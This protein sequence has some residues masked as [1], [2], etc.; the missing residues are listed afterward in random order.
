VEKLEE[1]GIKTVEKLSEMKVDELTK[2]VDG[3]GETTAQQY[4]DAA[5]KLVPSKPKPKKK[6][7]KKPKKPKPKAKEKKLKLTDID[8]LGP[9]TVEKL[10]ET[11]IKT[12]E[13]L[14]EMKVDELTK[15]VDGIGETTAQQY[16]DAAVELVPKKPKLEARP[17]PKKPKKPE[18]KVKEKKPKKAKPKPKKKRA[19]RKPKKKKKLPKRVEPK[20]ELLT[21]EQILASRIFR[22][23]KAKKRKQPSFRH[24]QN[25]RWMRVSK[26]WRKVR[27]IDSKTRE[28]RKGRP[29]MPN[30]GY[31]KPKAIRGIHPSGYIEKM[32]YRPSELED[33]DPEVHAVR[34]GS[35]VGLRKRQDILKKAETMMLRVLNPGAPETVM[36]EDLFSELDMLDEVE[37][38]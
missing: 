10:E 2:M 8:G 3:I 13:K 35:T 17:K 11:G 1:T 28:K 26:S 6:K 7:A 5:I 16:I 27:G 32:V 37:V 33:L 21:R 31:R 30:V 22:V 12:V 24:E 29:A 20:S 18:T 36:E 19:K 15:M 23:A 9:K 4:I 14:S 34:I 25:H 38:E